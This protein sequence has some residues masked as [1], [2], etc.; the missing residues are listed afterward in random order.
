MGR[1]VYNIIHN[2][3]EVVVVALAVVVAQVLRWRFP[4]ALHSV[5]ITQKI[6]IL[7]YQWPVLPSWEGYI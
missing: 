4:A 1:N 6:K 7:S 2:L 5:F 3:P